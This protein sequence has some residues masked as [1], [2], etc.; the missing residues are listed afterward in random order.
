MDLSNLE[1]KLVNLETIS[2]SNNLK[3]FIRF[4]SLSLSL[5]LFFF[6]ISS[7]LIFSLSIKF[8]Y[9]KTKFI[10]I[11]LVI[12]NMLAVHKTRKIDENLYEK[13]IRASNANLNSYFILYL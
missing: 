13:I 6:S 12:Y 4:L 3:N 1:A 7:L 2:V 8:R 9:E 5:F 10:K 11:F